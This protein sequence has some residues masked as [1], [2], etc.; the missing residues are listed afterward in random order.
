M[1]SVYH[2]R[3]AAEEP[4]LR[5]DRTTHSIRSP[6]GDTNNGSHKKADSPT[7]LDGSEAITRN[8]EREVC[9]NVD[10]GGYKNVDNGGKLVPEK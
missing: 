6:S 9:N 4:Q 3:C 2:W 5:F 7:P 1:V 8:E 10:A